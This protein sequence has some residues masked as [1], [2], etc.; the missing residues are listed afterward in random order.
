MS[1]RSAPSVPSHPAE[2]SWGGAVFLGKAGMAGEACTSDNRE[3]RG[4]DAGHRAG[5]VLGGGRREAGACD[6]EGCRGGHSR[7]PLG[8]CDPPCGPGFSLEAQHGRQAGQPL[9]RPPE[10]SWTGGQMSQSSQT[11]WSAAARP[12]LRPQTPHYPRPTRGRVL[13]SQNWALG[14]LVPTLL[15]PRD[16]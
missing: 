16:H 13:R 6:W 2:G 7:E 12:L 1:I 8:R 5:T 11:G 3:H 15:Q 14:D 9:R 10:D 4:P